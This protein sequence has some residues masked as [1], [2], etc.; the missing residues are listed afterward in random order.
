M[1]SYFSSYGIREHQPRVAVSTLSDLQCPVL[2]SREL[3]GR[4]AAA[5]GA[6]ELLDWLGAVFSG[7]EL[8]V[9]GPCAPGLRLRPRSGGRW[10]CFLFLL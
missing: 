7:A 9:R 6:P 3:G 4:P 1:T 8:C 10:Q 5:C 2:Q